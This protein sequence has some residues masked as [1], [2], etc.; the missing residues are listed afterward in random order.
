MTSAILYSGLGLDRAHS[1][2][3]GGDIAELMR[4]PGARFT[5]YWRG[6]QLVAGTPPA[7]RWLDRAYGLRLAE[8]TAGN[9]LLLGEDASGPLLALD[10]SGLEA[11]ENGPEM[12]GNWLWLRSVGGLLPAQDSAL[13][14]YARGV[15]VWR[16]K[17]RFCSSCGGPLLVQDSGHSTKCAAPSCGALHFPR[18]DPAIIM[19]VTDPAGRALLGRQPIWTPGMFSCLAGFVEP[20]ES[21]EGAVA[22]EVWE[23]AGIKI[24][25]TTYVASQPWPFP[26]SL[27]IGFNAQA[28]GGE[29]VADPHEIE[30]VRW[31][32]RDEVRT[33][34]EADR[35]GA[36]GRFLPRRDSIA[37]V[38]VEAW[39]KS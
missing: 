25:S 1:I 23:E 17:T 4:R 31:F 34:G 14:A 36:E 26:S 27:M 2:R 28:E 7:I 38:L 33:F 24:S 22:R 6:R 32:T 8:A 11:D 19:L 29:P 12:G 18:T 35:P 39:L 37:R 15:L 5:L 21:L 13:L 10:I 9:C 20:G 3:R 16:E 30:E